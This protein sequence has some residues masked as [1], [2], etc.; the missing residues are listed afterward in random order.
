[1][2]RSYTPL[3]PS[4]STACRGTTLLFFTLHVGITAIQN[5]FD[6]INREIVAS[7]LGRYHAN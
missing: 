7:V 2:C 5:T 1:M 3:P 4:A 6:T